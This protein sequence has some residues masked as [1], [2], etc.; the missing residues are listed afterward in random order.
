MSRRF[1][2]ALVAA[3]V[4]ATCFTFGL[5]HVTGAAADRENTQGGQDPNAVER[6]RQLYL[7]GCASCHGADG[8][9]TAQGVTLRGV[10]AASAD[11]QLTTGRMPSTQPNRQSVSKPPAYTRRQIADLVAY[12]ASLGPGPPIPDVNN[13]HGNLQEGGQL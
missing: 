2:T 3:P 7:V 4:A 8:R 11:F 13:P 9:G 6:G 1:V 10:G 5:A 12:V